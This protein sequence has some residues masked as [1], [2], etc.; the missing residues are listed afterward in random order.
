MLATVVFATVLFF[1][2]ISSKFANNRHRA[3]LLT[4]GGLMMLAGIIVLATFPV[5]V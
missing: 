4:M 1:A 5:E 2:G 3:A